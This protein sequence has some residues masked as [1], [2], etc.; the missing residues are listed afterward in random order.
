MRTDRL[1]AVAAVVA[2][3]LAGPGSAAAV[4]PGSN[5]TIV[6]SKCEDGDG[7]C[8]HS[9]IW[10]VDP[11]SG[12]EHAL[13]T[14]ASSWDDDPAVS[15]D[16]S[17]VAF[18][19]CHAVGKCGIA[20][21]DIGGGSVTDLT[22]ASG[23]E[24]NPAFSPDGTR[25][26]FARQ[27]STGATHLIVMDAAGGNERP[28]TGGPGSDGHASWSPDGSTIVFEHSDIGVGSQIRTVPASGGAS[29]A[30]TAGTADSAPSFSPDGS[31]VVFASGPAIQIMD[32]SGANRHALTAP[33]ANLRD[34]EPAF[35]PDG[36]QIVFERYSHA[37][38]PTS[39][40]LV[41][42]ADG[43]HRRLISGRSELLFRADWQPLHPT[44]APHIDDA[45]PGLTL[46]APAEES[47]RSGALHLFATSSEPVT[48][49]AR[50]TVARRHRLRQAATALSPNTPTR[51]RL[52]IPRKHR[53]GIRSA[54][55]RGMKP[56]AT[57]VVRVTDGAGNVTRKALTIRV[58]R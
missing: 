9:H 47:V 55:V 3:L 24:D 53:R 51:I 11:A 33:G 7:G 35:A 16:G 41:M 39:P 58:K 40:L 20:V 48:A 18:Q 4:V 6:V 45:A 30:L 1:V 46:T 10:T 32:A 54:L 56:R 26:V 14:D 23:Y 36:T 8:D 17:R 57:V 13:T 50:G 34:S 5:G 2:G 29:A 21:V 37:A 15:P 12:A 19:R 27:D 22:P 49:V 31:Q 43:S 44:P 25:L 28:L 42:N 38:P 52:S